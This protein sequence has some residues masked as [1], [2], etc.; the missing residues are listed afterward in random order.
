M[1]EIEADTQILGLYGKGKKSLLVSLDLETGSVWLECKKP[2]AFM[3]A[4]YDGVTIRATRWQKERKHRL[5]YPID[6]V[7]KEMYPSVEKEYFDKVKAD[8]KSR[9]V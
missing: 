7:A 8:I 3:C 1:T 4:T 5:L 2:S 9:A 6:W